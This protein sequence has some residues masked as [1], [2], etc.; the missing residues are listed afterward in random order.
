MPHAPSSRTRQLYNKTKQ[1]CPMAL[2]NCPECSGSLSNLAP[3]CPHCGMPQKMRA[4]AT[5][6]ALANPDQTSHTPKSAGA[7]EQIHS[8]RP[9][10]PIDKKTRKSTSAEIFGWL[11]ACLVFFSFSKLFPESCSTSYLPGFRGTGYHPIPI[12]S[13]SNNNQNSQDK[14]T[15]DAKTLEHL[16]N[17]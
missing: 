1:Y 17:R 12:P 11:F 2:I 10:E 8:K 6:A 5:P 13:G 3:T 7:G 14:Q 9:E 4:N 16:L 15:L